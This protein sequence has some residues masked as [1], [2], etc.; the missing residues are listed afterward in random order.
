VCNKKKIGE[1]ARPLIGGR[2]FFAAAQRKR[3]GKKE[4]LPLLK[5]AV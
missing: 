5:E 4:K 2:A 3:E 1:K